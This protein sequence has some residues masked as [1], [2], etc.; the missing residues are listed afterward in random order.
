MKILLLTDGIYPY[1]MGGMQKHSYYLAKY[2]SKKG[3]KVHVA[4]CY[5]KSK[6]E[7]INEGADPTHYTE[8][9]LENL[10]FSLFKFPKTGRLPGHYVRENWVYSCLIFDKL[11]KEL[12]DFDYIYAQ[13][14]VGWRFI[15]AR[16]D[17]K[18]KTPVLNNFHGIEMFQ[19]APNWKVKLQHYLL[20][21]P[22]LWNMQ[23][24]DKVFSF[25]AKI[26][27][28][29]KSIKISDDKI[30]EMPIGIESSW[31]SEAKNQNEVRQF[32]FIGRYER[33]KGIEE[34]NLALSSLM[35]KGV[36]NFH[37]NFIGP[38]D[39]KHRLKSEQIT[40]H[41]PI[42]E[43]DKIKEVVQS[44]DVL[45]V[46]SHSEGMPTVIMEGMASGLA[47]IATNVGAVSKQLDGN[48]WLLEGPKVALIENAIQ[49]AITIDDSTLLEMKKKSNR[50]VEEKFLWEKVVDQLLKE[51]KPAD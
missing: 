7:I 30:I 38:I 9:E 34:L 10:S 28:V 16:L 45:L 36:S 1:V 43:Q 33:R 26:G 18:L 3:V 23:N 35:E 49:E 13:G 11:K 42:Y 32:V 20:R 51:L 47:I 14:F 46:P 22:A 41:G 19:D 8:E 40:Y 31:L 24:A 2:L 27:D 37:V 17:N 12:E 4:H 50:I 15:K 29:L 25:G 39:Q 6:D 21:S 48:G 44:C 5:H